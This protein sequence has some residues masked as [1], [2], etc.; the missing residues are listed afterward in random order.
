MDENEVRMLRY[1]WEE[2]G[3][4]ERYSGWVEM[5]PWLREHHPEII[6][7]WD[8]YKMAGRILTAVIRAAE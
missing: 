1:F 4:L 7:A 5:Q 6:K 8:D 3:D 2:K